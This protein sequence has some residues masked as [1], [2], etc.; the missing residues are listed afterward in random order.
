MCAS[1]DTLIQDISFL[2]K[3]LN[4]IY[5]DDYLKAKQKWKNNIFGYRLYIKSLKNPEEKKVNIQF[6]E[7]ILSEYGAWIGISAKFENTPF[8]PHGFNGIFVSGDAVIGKDAVIFH[9]VT[10]GSNTIKD[11]KRFGSPT[12]GNNAYIGAGAKII[13]NIII[14]NNVRI[15]ANCVVTFDVPDDSVVVAEKARIIHKENMNNK[16]YR[17]IKGKY[18]YYEKGRFIEDQSNI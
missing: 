6:Y 17:R 8:F 10:I 4:D 9:Q 15:G 13:G 5:S 7:K 3:K 2:K 12:I 14:G 18:Y 11:S 1:I 16:F